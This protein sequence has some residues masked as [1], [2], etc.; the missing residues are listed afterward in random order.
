MTEHDL[1]ASIIAECDRRAN[2]DARWGFIMAVPNGQYRRGQRMEPGLR[3]GVPDLFLPVARHG[4]HGLWIEL[5][6]GRNKQ[7]VNQAKWAQDLYAL[8]YRVVVV[9]DEADEAIRIIKWYLGGEV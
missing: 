1:Q 4:Y 5:K 8:G 6:V 3:P 9:C 2:Q 7:T